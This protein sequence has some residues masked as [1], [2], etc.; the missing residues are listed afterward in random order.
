MKKNYYRSQ[1]WFQ[2]VF[3]IMKLTLVLCLVSVIQVIALP[4]VG[5]PRLNLKL[6]NTSIE[7]VLQNVEEN[8][9]YRFFYKSEDLAEKKSIT[10]DV[11]QKDVFEILDEILPDL[12]LTYEVFDKYIAIKSSEASISEQTSVQQKT[13]KG[14]VT[15]ENGEPLP[16]VTVVIKGT[17]QGTV[18]N[19]NGEFNLSG[20]VS[21]SVVQFSFVGMAK[22]EI[23][24]GT[25]AM[26]NVTMVANAIG[27]EEVVAIGY[28]IVKK[29]DLTGSVSSIKAGEIER[30][31]VLGVDQALQSRASG[32]LVSNNQSNP[33]GNVSI[34]I[35]GI[36]SIQGNNEPLY[37]VDGY[38]GGN[39]NT[40]NPNDIESIEV[41]KDAS[42]TSIYGS[43]GAN[44]VVI[45][46]TKIGK[47]GQHNIN[48]DTFIG[49][50]KVR[51]KLDLFNSGQYVDF[52]T[53]LDEEEQ[54]DPFYPD[55]SSVT[56]DTDWQDEVLRTAPWKQYALSATGS[57]EKLSY[58]FSGAFVEQQGIIKETK[59]GRLNL[60]ANIDANVTDN[61]KIGT[62][63]GFADIERTRISG[64][65]TGRLDDR[66]NPIP[67][68]TELRPTIDPYDSN[69]DLLATIDSNDGLN[70]LGVPL[71]DLRNVK[72]S[73]SSIN[74]NGNLYAEIKL[75]DF[76]T[77]RSSGGLDIVNTKRYSY[78][79]STVFY[80]TSGFRNSASLNDVKSTG[81]LFE[82]Y[83]KYNK[84]YENHDLQLVGGLTLQ[85]NDTENFGI[86]VSDFAIDNFEFNNLAAGE[87]VNNYGSGLSEWKQISTFARL[88]YT[89]MDKYLFT[90]NGRYDGNSKFGKDNKW[91]FFPS[92]AIAWRLGDEDFIKNFNIFS[93][94][95]LRASYGISGSEALGPYRS[96]T[97][98]S[99][100][101]QAYVI[102]NQPVVGYFL[103]RLPNPGLEWEKTKQWDIGADFG[104]FNGRISFVLDYFS[105]VTEDLFLNK[106]VP[107]TS[108]VGSI[109][110]N[111]G[112]IT[113]NGFEF[114]INVTPVRKDKF[115]WQINLNGTYQTSEVLD[116]GDESGEIISGFLGGGLGIG[117]TT[118][119]KEGEKLGAFYGLR[120]DGVWSTSD[121]LNAYTQFGQPVKPGDLK[122]I[123]T[124][125]DD[126]VTAEDREIIGYA[127]P[128]FFGGLNNSLTYG[129]WDLSFFI[130]YI[131]GNDILN[132]NRLSLWNPGT[133][134]N[135]SVN[136][137]NAWTPQ[138]QNTDI[139][140][141]GYD[142]PIA[143]TDYLLED[144][145]V[146]RL[147]E[148]T[149]GYSF[150]AKLLEKIRIK[151]LRLYAT[152]M[153]M[154]A[155]SKYS[156][157][158]PE[159]NIG[160]GSID[161]LN[162]DNGSYPRSKTFILG[163]NLTF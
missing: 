124:N 45:V 54:Q 149:L 114:A 150:D 153:N 105:K 122:L 93:N 107:Q 56:A 88:Q 90:F 98:L 44:G 157:Y 108:G 33:G 79:P 139:P 78:K 109:Q 125:D 106:P 121:D 123:D 47:K 80:S 61:I 64:E 58:F 89:L 131:G 120:S 71:F 55:P 8:S 127:Q 141:V 97:Q 82:N 126:D 96:L 59:Y 10:V 52:I 91:G 68:S 145:S 162:L 1:G 13:V 73:Q 146:L 77:F 140:R 62:R 158:D 135:K 99:T 129:G 41:L 27:I 112:S 104:I 34:R 30:V 26:I 159:V 83:L 155:F 128:K 74:F 53:K 76:L 103:S 7:D 4:S 119:I 94:F 12:Q 161:I 92:G 143:M 118:I 60:R 40:V 113:N 136:L 42:S 11:V 49:F 2:K 102:G 86:S 50:Q 29:R 48:F 23:Q 19:F 51:K 115:T 152:G 37:I 15:D 156:G 133:R 87:T 57:T 3:C 81:W 63:I 9:V 67:R 142:L 132:A 75:S 72:Q 116:L 85:G 22:Q 163:L 69:G 110:D 39:I 43:R 130:Q 18:T 16:G 84:D 101:S 36:N 21:E 160:A 151:K 117:N 5:Q 66:S 137:L 20:I 100:D 14:R 65:D 134:S 70:T 35:R 32:V 147:K 38:I 28:G 25:Q 95:K 148:V 17:T 6:K 46:T 154:L 111:I 138:K 24:V 31:P 144:G